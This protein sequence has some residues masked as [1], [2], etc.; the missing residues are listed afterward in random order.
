MNGRIGAIAD[1]A[2]HDAPFVLVAAIYTTSSTT[3]SSYELL[4]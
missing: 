3:E 4:D 2:R 1:H